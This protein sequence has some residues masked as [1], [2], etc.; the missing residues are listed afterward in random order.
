MTR[1]LTDAP[2]LDDRGARCC[3]STAVAGPGR[4][5]D[6]RRASSPAGPARTWSPTSPPT[7]RRWATWCTGRPPGDTDADVRLPRAAG[8]R[9]RA[10][11]PPRPRAELVVLVRA[12][13]RDAR[14]RR[15]AGLT[16]EPVAGRGPYR[17]GPD[18]SRP[19]RSRGCAHA[20]L[21]A[22]GRP[23][24]RAS[25]SPTSPRTSS[26]RSARTWSP[27]VQASAAAVAVSADG[28]RWSCRRGPRPGRV[29]SAA[30]G[31][32]LP[33]GTPAHPHHDRRRRRPRT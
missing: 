30:A 3:S 24:H 8:R 33:D 20:R 11:V 12:A 25:G 2:A 19:P 16:D 13:R 14:R 21:G 10:R 5:R 15:L 26:S 9:H 23:R 31:G 29:R 27:S 6:R 32:G 4:G 18:R 28:H 22:R 7:P 17:P 1:T